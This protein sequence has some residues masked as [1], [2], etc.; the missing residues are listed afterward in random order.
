MLREAAAQDRRLEGERREEAR[1]EEAARQAIIDEREQ[2]I[3]LAGVDEV[4]EE[5]NRRERREEAARQARLVRDD[6]ERQQAAREEEFR[7]QNQEVDRRIRGV[8][9]G[10]LRNIASA[11]FALE[12][13]KMQREGLRQ[14]LTHKHYF[15]KFFCGI[16]V[17]KFWRIAVRRAMERTERRAT[18][19]DCM[20]AFF[21]IIK[22]ELSSLFTL[23]YLTTDFIY[24]GDNI[25]KQAKFYIQQVKRTMT[26]FP[27]S[28]HFDEVVGPIE[29]RNIDERIEQKII[30]YNDNERSEISLLEERQARPQRRRRDAEPSGLFTPPGQIIRSTP[31]SQIRNEITWICR[32]CGESHTTEPQY[33]NRCP[34]IM[35]SGSSGRF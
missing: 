6:V 26:Q 14:P 9:E 5:A 7:L 29:K 8:D 28:T 15:V 2:A 10:E 31:Q 33:R 24:R 22:R 18:P 3:R 27:D 13:I 4:I 34:D 12:I 30:E 21:E 23:P 25:R 35:P 11:M 1:R 17:P 20:E 19:E 16:N 32:D